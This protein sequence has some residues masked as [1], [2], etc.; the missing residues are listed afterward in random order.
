M[1]IVTGLNANVFRAVSGSL[2]SSPVNWSRGVV[3]TGSDV[4]LIADNCMIDVS[5][6]V[7]SLI[8]QPGFTAS[9]SGSITFRVDDTINVLGQI[10]CSGAPTVFVASKKNSI[11]SL[12]AGN[13]TFRFSSSLYDQTVPG[14]TYNN[15][16]IDGSSVKRLSGNA[17]ISGSNCRFDTGPAG[18][19]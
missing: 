2:F 17:V 12:S 18:F 8:V 15:V 11:S 13:S 10:S 3:P 19:F 4:A 6:T 7:G 16:I 5:R 14:V 1:P 9:I